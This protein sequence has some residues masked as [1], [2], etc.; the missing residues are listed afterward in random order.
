MTV[1]TMKWMKLCVSKRAAVG[2]P[3]KESTPQNVT[4]R[5]WVS[6][7]TFQFTCKILK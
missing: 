7:C 6:K 2:D 5:K 4:R 1:V 3:Q